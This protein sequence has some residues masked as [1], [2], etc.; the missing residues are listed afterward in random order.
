MMKAQPWRLRACNGCNLAVPDIGETHF[1]MC[2]IDLDPSATTDT[3]GSNVLRINVG[4]VW[5]LEHCVATGI[6][7]ATD[8]NFTTLNSR[9][10][11]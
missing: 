4:Q 1:S 5:A 10:K 6:L 2:Y 8:Y 7:T 3:H 11:R 9:Q